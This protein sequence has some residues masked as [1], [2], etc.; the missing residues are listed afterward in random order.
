VAVAMQLKKLDKLDQLDR[1]YAKL[2]QL[3]ERSAPRSTR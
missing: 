1:L 3:L 2:E